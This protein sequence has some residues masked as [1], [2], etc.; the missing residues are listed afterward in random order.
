MAVATRSVIIN[1]T[2]E[3]FY[4]V[5]ADFESYPEFCNDVDDSTAS[6]LLGVDLL[7]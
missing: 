6:P 3:E 1:V 5:V 7:R 4:S 2:P